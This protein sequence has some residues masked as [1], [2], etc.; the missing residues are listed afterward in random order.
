MAR[1]KTSTVIRGASVEVMPPADEAI[2]WVQSW[3]RFN[4]KEIVNAAVEALPLLGEDVAGALIGALPASRRP[5]FARLVLAQLAQAGRGS[6]ESGSGG[7]PSLGG[8][9]GSVA[10]PEPVER[11]L[12]A[13]AS[14]PPERTEGGGALPP[15]GGG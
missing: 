10:E 12:R 1:K 8:R 4:R 9:Q 5:D 13:A 7:V 11:Y 14:D 6:P 3:S 2:A 15:S